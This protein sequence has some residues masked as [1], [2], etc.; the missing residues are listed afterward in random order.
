[1][2][3]KTCSSKYVYIQVEISV[4][5]I[6]AWKA[7]SDK[8]FE[9]NISG[10]QPGSPRGGEEQ[11]VLGIGGV[12]E[13]EEEVV[14]TEARL[15]GLFERFSMYGKSL[16]AEAKASRE[17]REGVGGQKST[18]KSPPKKE[19]KLGESTRDVAAAAVQVYVYMYIYM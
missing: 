15:L 11:D 18:V 10:S 4:V 2:L 5:C 7:A 6:P 3:P 16:A 8:S 13:G 12:L 17:D 9:D 14:T 19:K 1:M